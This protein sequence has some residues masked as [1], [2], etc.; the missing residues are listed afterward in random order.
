MT[1]PPARKIFLDWLG[2]VVDGAL[3]PGAGPL[4]HYTNA[5]GLK[6]IVT[7]DRLWATDTAFLNDSVELIYGVDLALAAM[8]A[9]ADQGVSASTAR[10]MLALGEP[11]SGILRPFLDESLR[12]FVTCFCSDDDLL[13]WHAGT[14]PSPPARCIGVLSSA[15]HFSRVGKKI[16]HAL[17]SVRRR[18][19]RRR[20]RDSKRRSSSSSVRRRSSSID[21]TH[22]GA[23]SA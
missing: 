21:S 7:R 22:A 8:R 15:W 17:S 16:A 1:A 20:V 4:W 23:R 13:R 6:G 11:G 10:L 18:A 14:M 9:I 5:D 19:S 3:T 12:L 2:G